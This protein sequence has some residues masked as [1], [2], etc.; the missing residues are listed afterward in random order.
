MG[1]M[2][3]HLL[4][5]SWDWHNPTTERQFNPNAPVQ[6]WYN[7]AGRP[8]L[9]DTVFEE[10]LQQDQGP[11]QI[12]PTP[13]MLRQLPN[14]VVNPPRRSV[15]QQQPVHQPDNVYRYEAPIDIL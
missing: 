13:A 6:E 8:D 7:R 10:F 2:G 11:H 12:S 5:L 14:P 9:D 3:V 15:Q 4:Q 1:I